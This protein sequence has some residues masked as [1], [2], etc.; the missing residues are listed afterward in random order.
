MKKIIFIV[1]VFVCISFESAAQNDTNVGNTVSV[2]KEKPK[3]KYNNM[4]F[5]QF[6]EFF[7]NQ[8]YG[9]IYDLKSK[10]SDNE[11]FR[12]DVIEAMKEIHVPIVRWPGGCFVSTYHWMDG[13]GKERVST[14]DK[15]W[16]VENTNAFGTDEYIK[17]CH[18]VGCQPYI[19]TNAGTGTSEEMSNW[20]EYC[21]LRVGKYGKMRASNGYPEP[22]NVKYWSIGNENYGSWELGAHTVNDWGPMVCESAKLLRSVTKDAKLFAAATSDKNW[23]IP[24]LKAA[25]RQLDY[26]SLHGY[27]DALAHYNNPSSFVECMQ[28]TDAPEQDIQKAIKLL[29]ESGY[30][31]GKI[32]IAY[33]EWNLRGWHHPWHGDLRQGFDIQARRKNDI[34]STYTMADALFSACFLNAC[35]RHSDIVDIACFSPIVN[36]RG[37][38]FVHP[39]GIVK[40]TTFYTFYMYTN[41]LE[42]YIVPVNTETDAL[43]LGNHSTGV[44]D[45]ILTTNEKNTRYVCA[46]VNKDAM[47]DVDLK[48][49]FETFKKASPKKIKAEILS[50]KSA[51]DFNDIGAENRVVPFE[52]ILSVKNSV[53]SIPAHSL[54]FL[55]IE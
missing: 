39:D 12:K 1:V 9:G 42:K 45:I 38:I 35:L 18:K 2:V 17:W 22:Y 16:Q 41:F 44:F 31:N 15:A 46:V 53:V 43:Q 7:D 26:I 23:T 19:C 5:G 50:G 13:I 21:N 40:R 48:I 49:N 54:T 36:T 28:R 27:W 30:G 8:I 47:K 4:I 55:I 10:F 25:G 29:D 52:K 6:I 20:M 34:A 51:D 14:Y 32:K 37:A 3:I 24:L 11:G 33:D